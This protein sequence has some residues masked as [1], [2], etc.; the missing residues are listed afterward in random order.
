ML[1][2]VR[3]WHTQQ[4]FGPSQVVTNRNLV[5][6][7]NSKLVLKPLQFA[8]RTIQKRSKNGLNWTNEIQRGT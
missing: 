4:E 5:F 3:S 8:F 1:Q 7:S 6:I 2:N